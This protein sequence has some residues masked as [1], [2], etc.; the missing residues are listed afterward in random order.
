LT[1]T[2]TYDVGAPVSNFLNLVLLDEDISNIYFLVPFG[3]ENNIL[4]WGNNWLTKITNPS[5]YI[6]IHSIP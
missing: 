5:R 4:F 3:D 1:Q 2:Q 6:A